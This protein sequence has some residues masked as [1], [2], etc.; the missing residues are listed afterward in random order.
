MHHE[1]LGQAY[2]V[3]T[4]GQ[5]PTMPLR[6]DCGVTPDPQDTTGLD[7]MLSPPIREG[8]PQERAMKFDR[9]VPDSLKSFARVSR[10]EGLWAA[11]SL[12]AD[13]KTLVAIGMA[14]GHTR[15]LRLFGMRAR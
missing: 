2:A 13:G 12:S 3:N 8:S 11:V 4:V 14:P 10:T 9:E 6:S 15:F 1:Q 7:L 5:T